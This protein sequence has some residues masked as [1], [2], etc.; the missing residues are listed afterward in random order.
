M[1]TKTFLATI[2]YLS[3]AFLISPLQQELGFGNDQYGN[4]STAFS[5]GLTAGAFFWEL[6][7]E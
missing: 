4:T 6:H 5:S 1:S 3:P 2:E 7:V